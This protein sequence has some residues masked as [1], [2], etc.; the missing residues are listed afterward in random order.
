VS[1]EKV[2]RILTIHD[3]H[4]LATAKLLRCG[5]GVALLRFLLRL[6]QPPPVY[7]GFDPAGSRAGCGIAT[8]HGIAFGCKG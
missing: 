1:V 8:W 7:R 2:R 4:G 6:N 5:H 3:R